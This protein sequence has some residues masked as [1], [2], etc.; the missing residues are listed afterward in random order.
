[1]NLKKKDIAMLIFC[2]VGFAC[3]FSRPALQPFG[4]LSFSI[5]LWLQVFDGLQTGQIRS[6]LGL[7]R[8][9]F[10]YDRDENPILFT[11]AMIIQ[12]LL[13]A[14]CFFVFLFSL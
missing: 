12:G 3:L 1:M 4:W 8:M 11:W 5:G 2:I 9:S 10:T 14:G 6:T 7:G 13:A